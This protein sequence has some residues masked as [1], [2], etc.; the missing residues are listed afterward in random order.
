MN[1][2]S[3]DPSHHEQALLPRSYMSLLRLNDVIS[4]CD[5]NRLHQEVDV[6]QRDGARDLVTASLCINIFVIIKLSSGVTESLLFIY[7]GGG[8]AKGG[9]VG[10]PSSGRPRVYPSHLLCT[11]KGQMGGGEAIGGSLCEWMA[12]PPPP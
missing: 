12:L 2:R 7:L 1:D 6:N 4:D 8:V 11:M 10:R 5:N 9:G 3:D